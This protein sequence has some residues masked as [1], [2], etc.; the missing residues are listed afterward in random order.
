MRSTNSRTEHNSMTS[1]A[2]MHAIKKSP[3]SSNTQMWLLNDSVTNIPTDRRPY[4][5]CWCVSVGICY[6]VIGCYLLDF[7]WV[8]NLYWHHWYQKWFVTNVYWK[9][10]NF[11]FI[12]LHHVLNTMLACFFHYSPYCFWCSIMF[13]FYILS[14]VSFIFF[15]KIN[16]L[17]ACCC[18][19]LMF[20]K[21]WC[22]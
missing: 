8:R 18:L 2:T 20:E 4:W 19:F 21:S 1:V 14:E 13:F 7:W 15:I 22:Q 17:L 12:F 3:K 6:C 16:I 10:V 11:Y 5:W 9:T